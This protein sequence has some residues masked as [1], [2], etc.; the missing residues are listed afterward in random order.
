M[1]TRAVHLAAVTG[2]L[3]SAVL[4]VVATAVFCYFLLHP[5]T[6]PSGPTPAQLGPAATPTAPATD[7]PAT[8]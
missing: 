6:A 3:L 8:H 4:A 5:A 7:Y 2:K 1:N